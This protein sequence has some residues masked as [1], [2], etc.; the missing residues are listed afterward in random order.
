MK[1]VV[2]F[3]ATGYT[4]RLIVESLSGMGG[5]EVILAGR[6]E[7]R[8]RELSRQYG[9]LEYRV[10]DVEQAVP[11][12]AMLRGAEV[13]ID[14]VGPFL[15]FGEP[16]VRAAI[17]QGVH[18]LDITA[19]Q[20]YMTRILERYDSEARSRR[21]AVV[22]AH[23]LEFAV[24]MCAAALLS[25]SDPSVEAI[26]LFTRVDNHSWSRGSSKSSLGA[27]FQRQLILRDGQVKPRPSAFS[28]LTV[29]MPDRGIV[30]RAIPFPGAEA[31]HLAR[32]C[33]AVRNAAGY[34]IMPAAQAR[35]AMAVVAM[36]RFLKAVLRPRMLA[37]ISNRIDRGPEGPSAAERRSQTFAILA[38]G[39]TRQGDSAEILVSGAD[40][41]GMTGVIAALGAKLLMEHG[42][43]ELGVT[44]TPQI[45]GA[46]AFLRALEPWGV[47]TRLS[48]ASLRSAA[49]GVNCLGVN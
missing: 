20:S 47:T 27:L 49:A 33:P 17:Q 18:C 30:E 14:A 41:Y 38:R 13:L 24:G 34:L 3:G 4:G 36:T 9:G 2:V 1:S 22:N 31:L 45:F 7:T 35:S 39:V 32:A 37:A 10:A 6:D 12:S 44:S 26:D 48:G 46:G 21:V 28:P 25:E 43:K 29:R 23:G 15:R 11:L 8:L 16:V 19:E 40:A 5:A 42:P